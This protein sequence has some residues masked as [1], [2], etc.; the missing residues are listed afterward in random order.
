MCLTQSCTFVDKL[1]T[2]DESENTETEPYLQA[3]R[4][5]LDEKFDNIITL[6]TTE[7]DKP[8]RRNTS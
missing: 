3:V 6:C 2:L 5:A 7:I 1:L 4:E 8:G